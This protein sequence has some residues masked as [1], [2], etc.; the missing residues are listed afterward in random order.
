MPLFKYVVFETIAFGYYLLINMQKIWPLFHMCS[1]Y[2]AQPNA[3]KDSTYIAQV[4]FLNDAVN[5][6]SK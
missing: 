3:C 1:I 6:F 4:V 5:S 2:R